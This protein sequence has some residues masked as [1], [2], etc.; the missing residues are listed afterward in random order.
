M[1]YGALNATI[2]CT[3]KVCSFRVTTKWASRRRA[4]FRCG[5][6]TYYGT[7]CTNLNDD[8]KTAALFSLCFSIH[9]SCPTKITVLT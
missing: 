1:L 9:R 6:P 4:C 3:H 2:T 5:A 8:E 7:L